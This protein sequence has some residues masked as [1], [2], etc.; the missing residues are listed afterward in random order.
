[1]F[2]KLTAII[3]GTLIALATGPAFA[4]G[5]PVG[6]VIMELQNSIT[7][8][9]GSVDTLQGSVDDLQG[10][11]DTLQ[12]SVDDL[13]NLTARKLVFVTKDT[14]P[15][16]LGG[17]AGADAKC[18][19]AANTAGLGG[20]WQAWL[21]DSTESPT[22]RWE[23]LSWGPYYDILGNVIA[24]DFG[25]LTD[26]ALRVPIERA[27]DNTIIGFPDNTWSNTRFTGARLTTTPCDD[28]TTTNGTASA[29]GIIGEIDTDWTQGIATL[30]GSENH[31]YC[32]EQ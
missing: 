12:G 2:K 31:L 20:V 23:T 13:Q 15:A 18:Q 5:G 28:W 30:C 9:Q 24:A 8:L 27:Q 22:T 19:A 6:E 3:V 7:T 21:S 17:L 29:G 10:F 16:T 11:A 1:M 4:Q 14:F 32:F 25:D 26:G